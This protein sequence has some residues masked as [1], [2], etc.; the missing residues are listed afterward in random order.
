MNLFNPSNPN[1]YKKLKELII[2]YSCPFTK[3]RYGGIGDSSYVFLKELM[4]DSKNIYSYG[5]G[6]IPASMSFDLECANNGKKIYMYD[7][8]VERLPIDHDNF[9]F[10][11][12]H[13]NKGNFIEHIRENNHQEE[14]NMALKM[15]IECHE[16]EV[17]EKNID[18]VN[19]HFNQISMEAH[20]LI[21]ELPNGWE[22]DPFPLYIRKNIDIKISFFETINKY[23]KIVHL[24]ANNHGPI[25]G[26]FPDTLEI[27]FLRNDFPV[28]EIEQRAYPLQ[29][30]DYPNLAQREDYIL[31]WWM[32]K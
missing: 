8:S 31:N 22:I 32:N 15:D 17:L 11:K 27:T 30:F 6:H 28:N 29:G 3:K 18:L 26:D 14:F 25:Y 10:K 4:E 24:H 9:I 23:Y 1:K 7:G 12:Q 13:L 16:Y 2:P 21:E 19:K 20:S 5:V